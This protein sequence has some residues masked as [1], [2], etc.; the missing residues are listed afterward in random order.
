MADPIEIAARGI[1]KESH[2]LEMWDGETQYAQDVREL[3]HT[4]A[5]AAIRALEDAGLR[6]VGPEPTEEMVEAGRKSP[7]GLEWTWLRMQVA[8]PRWTGE[9]NG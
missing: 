8:A 5:R 4:D 7:I 9:D 6:I 1:F 3:T 2:C